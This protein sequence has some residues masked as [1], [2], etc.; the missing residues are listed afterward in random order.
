MRQIGIFVSFNFCK[1]GLLGCLE[2]VWAA[3]KSLK[4]KFRRSDTNEWSKND[5][6]LLA[7]VEHGEVDKVVALLAKKGASATKQDSEGKTA[8]HLAATRGQ[9]ECLAAILAHGVDTSLTDGSG[10]SALHLAAK[11]N[12]HD[13]AMK[14]IQS[15]CAI[16]TLDGS[17][18]TALHHAA[19]CGNVRI[20]Q[21]LCE[22]KSPVNLKDA[23]GFTSLLLSAHHAHADVCRTLMDFGADVNTCDKSG[24]TA[25]MLASES[26]CLAAVELLVQNGAGL[27]NVDSLGHDVL[28]Y[29]KISGNSEIQSLLCSA[30]QRLKNDSAPT[31]PK[32]LQH[33]LVGGDRS[34]TPKKR[35]APPPPSSLVQNAP[36]P[37][38]ASPPYL[39]PRQT[40]LSSNNAT[41]RKFNF[42][43]EEEKRE[44]WRQEM[45]KMQEEK[46]MLLETIE[47]LKQ[48]LQQT[49][50]M[51]GDCGME[52]PALVA[53]LQAKIAAL[54]LENQQLAHI[55]KKQQREEGRGDSRPNSIDSTASFH[56]SHAEL[57]PPNQAN[58]PTQQEVLPG[59]SQKTERDGG[60]AEDVRLLS[61]SLRSLQAKLEEAQQENQSLQAR[62]SAGPAPGPEEAELRAEIAAAEGRCQEAQ[63]EVQALR[64][65]L[66]HKEDEV[67]GR[68]EAVEAE[69][70]ELREEVGRV[71]EQRDGDEGTIRSLQAQL[72]AARGE[73]RSGEEVQ[74]VEELKSSYA[75]LLEQL[76]QQKDLSASRQE[77]VQEQVRLLQEAL[78]GTVPA[79]AAARD[80]EEMKAELGLVIDGLQRKLEE[81]T[82]SY[83]E[84]QSRLEAQ[85]TPDP[86]THALRHQAEEARAQR[87]K[88]LEEIALLRREA[89]TQAKSTVALADH[90]QVVAS[91]GT[92]LK[93]AESEVEDLKQRLAELLEAES[94]VEQLKERLAEKTL[95]VEALQNRLTVE[96]DVTPDDSVSRVE[97]Q[98]MR[99]GLEAE[100]SQLTLL[101]QDAL[102]KQDEMALEMAAAW[103]E[104]RDE[105]SA[106]EALRDQLETAERETQQLCSKNR[107][108]QETIADLRARE[109]TLL[110][111]EQDKKKKIEELNKEV[112]RLKEA[113]N[114]LSQ[115]SYAP[116]RQSSQLEALQQQVKQLQ[117]QLAEAKKRHHEVVSVYRM[118]LLYAVQGQ[119]D[120]DVQK[121]LKQILM[122]CKMPTEAK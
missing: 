15:K 111:S 10:Y 38:L 56:S 50:P 116:K 90:T 39:T 34:A 48:I 11:N 104:V 113:L 96:K 64:E 55:L 97:H 82:R 62:L 53:T 119:M 101:L 5:E 30:L 118:H 63:R 110:S 1:V 42:Q 28:H 65:Q 59:A 81:L 18:K 16:D 92:A 13:C 114:S 54:A 89:E 98:Q 77:E 36:L 46:S 12:Q 103:Q 93:E 83:D 86:E 41:P 115:L 122:M 67:M 121:A 14:L 32:P 2:T 105:R 120:E 71:R 84:A 35:K 43:E 70:Q 58:P 23:E 27:Q 74:E 25:L 100:V 76:Q 33:D 22:N 29:A 49:H 73:R 57:E 112:S 31:S 40:P 20:V 17:G 52:E 4:A 79:E 37:D 60:G 108:A 26:G 8:L 91:L 7:A 107:S 75:S 3:M 68:R 94:E 19:A 47:D 44:V 66:R 80:F 24:R 85:A 61:E 45:E 6:R 109:E 95:Q 21:L 106:K 9:T 87:D 72:E 102:R 88:A 99:E 69:L 117:Y 51:A 78:K